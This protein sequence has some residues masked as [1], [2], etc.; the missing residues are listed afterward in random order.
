MEFHTYV[1]FLHWLPQHHHQ[2]ALRRLGKTAWAE[3]EN[4]N[5]L[6]E[7]SLRALFPSGV[8]PTVGCARLFGMRSNILAY[9]SS[10]PAGTS[11]LAPASPE[12]GAPIPA[13]A[14]RDGSQ[15]RAS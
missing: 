11:L 4:L 2:R 1:P 5:L 9:G 8:D 6:D 10:V 3:T 13:P 7:K 14:P 15:I 12:H